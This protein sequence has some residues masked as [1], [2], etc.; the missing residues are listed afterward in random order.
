MRHRHFRI[1]RA[2]HRSCSQPIGATGRP[3]TD[4]AIAAPDNGTAVTDKG[5]LAPVGRNAVPDKE[6]VAPDNQIVVPDTLASWL[7]ARRNSTYSV[8][9]SG[10]VQNWRIP[11]R[12]PWVGLDRAWLL[13]RRRSDHRHDFM[14]PAARDLII[15][16]TISKPFLFTQR[17]QEPCVRTSGHSIAIE[18]AGERMQA[19]LI[20]DATAATIVEV[21]RRTAEAKQ[22]P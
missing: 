21:Y 12:D 10:R 4:N 17:S 18:P 3:S 11:S 14:A 1:Y 13:A 15:S 9:E 2:G 22:H 8:Q 20:G 6:V 19:F 7:R 16:F 5:I